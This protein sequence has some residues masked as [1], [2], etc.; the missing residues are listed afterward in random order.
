VGRTVGYRVGN[1]DHQQSKN[2]KIVFCTVGYLLAFLSHNP[3]YFSSITHL[4][5]DEVHERSVD[6]DSLNFLIK[7]MMES[8][9]VKLVVMSATLQTGTF[10][11]YFTPPSEFVTSPIFVGAR[12][13]EVQRIFLDSLATELSK[14]DEG[15]VSK[16]IAR[17][18]SSKVVAK[19][20]NEAKKLVVQ[21]IEAVALKGSTTLVFLP[22][23]D[24]ICEVQEEIYKRALLQISVHVLHSQV[25]QEDQDKSL[26]PPPAGM[27]KVIL[28]TNIAESSITIPDVETVIDSGVFCVDKK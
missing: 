14:V 19:L 4:L 8:H 12:R 21:C 2:T 1:G 7:K 23:M 22:G 17:F 6:A 20:S 25:P 18:C 15:L 5:L 3:E 10:G 9:P 26:A 28:A 16:A 24:E 27:R 13:F 11:Q